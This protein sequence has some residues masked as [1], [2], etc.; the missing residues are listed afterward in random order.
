MSGFAQIEALIAPGI[1]A[2]GYELV[3]VIMLGNQ[4]PT[5]QIMVERVD[6]AHMTVDDCAAVSKAVSAILDVED[7]IDS[8]YLLEV[9]SPGLDRPLTRL[10]DFDRFA[11]NETKVELDPPV[12]GRRRFRGMLLGTEEDTILLRVDDEEMRLPF[13]SVRKAK[14]VLTDALI[15][16]AEKE[17]REQ[18]GQ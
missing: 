2:L 10:K 16:Q 18:E 3:R 9:S 13:A 8:N 7:P 17:Y 6:G 1:E 12:D 11:G 15:A 5:L 14:L 4:R